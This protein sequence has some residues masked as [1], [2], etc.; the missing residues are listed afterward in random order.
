[1][2]AQKF[3]P[4]SATKRKL[5]T[6]LNTPELG[7]KKYSIEQVHEG[8]Q[9]LIYGKSKRAASELSGVP[10]NTLARHFKHL[11]GKRCNV[12]HPLTKPERTEFINKLKNSWEPKQ[13]G[14]GKRLFL[15][16][17][18]L[19]IIE[20]L[21]TAAQAA[22]PYNADALEATALNL[23]KA[24]YGKDFSLGTR[25]NW[26]KGFEKRW[27]SRIAKVKSSSICQR[28]AAAATEEVRDKV[29]D[30]FIE[31]V[32]GLVQQGSLTPA[33]RQNLGN[34]IA[35]CDEVGGHEQGKRKK[36]YEGKQQKKRGQKKKKKW[37]TTTR[38]GDHN[39]FHTT[40]MF[41]SMANGTLFPGISIIHSAPGSKTPRMRSDLYTHLP[42]T[43]HVRRTT[44]GNMTREL[45]QDWAVCV[46][47]FYD[48][49]ATCQ[50]VCACLCHVAGHVSV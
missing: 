40:K 19:M 20:M 47:L 35:N 4:K 23:G 32:D 13:M 30:H 6:A 27:S 14:Q 33:Q 50:P 26:R 8:L 46:C 41:M 1:M 11:T 37:R 25:S 45:F 12:K 28:R 16:H 10:P 22:F 38:D 31:F 43:W 7:Y 9:A 36:V 48:L 49:C 21:E 3:V 18:E 15:P 44:S 24:A 5:K 2:N 17:E 34:H 29:Y 42:G 39:P